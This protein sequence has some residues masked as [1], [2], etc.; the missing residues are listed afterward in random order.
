MPLAKKA[1]P[2]TATS[3]FVM[4]GNYVTNPSNDDNM[5]H[6][7]YKGQLIKYT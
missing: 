2:P 5:I 6:A 3:K 4:G 7:V 1:Q